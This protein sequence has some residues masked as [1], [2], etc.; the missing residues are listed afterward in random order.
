M[1]AAARFGVLRR[2]PPP[3]LLP[4]RLLSLAAQDNGRCGFA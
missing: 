1:G 3:P 4:Y 2:A